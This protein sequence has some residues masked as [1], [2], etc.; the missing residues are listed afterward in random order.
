MRDIKRHPLKEKTWILTDTTRLFGFVNYSF[1]YEVDTVHVANGLDSVVRAPM[2]VVLRQQ[3][4]VSATE[5]GCSV[6]TEAVSIEASAAVMF[7]VTGGMDS[8]HRELRESLAS[9]AEQ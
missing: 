3:W 2:G 9:L 5:N 1:N 4:R 7:T 8:S 6:L